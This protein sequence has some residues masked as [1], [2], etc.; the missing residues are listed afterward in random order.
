[1]AENVVQA[2]Q[3]V[4]QDIIVPELRELKVELASFRREMGQHFDS[5]EKQMNQGSAE[6]RFDSIHAGFDSF[7]KQS[8]ARHRELLAEIRKSRPDGLVWQEI[9]SLRERVAV[10]EATWA[11]KSSTTT[12]DR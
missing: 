10:L 9:A 11:R 4:V 12:L 7:E 6:Q 1:M 3:K 2:L 8:E 5:L